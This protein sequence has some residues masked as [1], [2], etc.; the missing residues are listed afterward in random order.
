[1]VSYV[2][3]IIIIIIIII[4][5]VPQSESVGRTTVHNKSE[6]NN[7]GVNGNN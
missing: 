6:Q 3:N 7:V 2:F 4:A 1:M 5:Y